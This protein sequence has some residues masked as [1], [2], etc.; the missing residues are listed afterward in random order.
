MTVVYPFLNDSEMKDIFNTSI[1]DLFVKM[2]Q[3]CHTKNLSM[4]PKYCFDVY[5]DKKPKY[6]ARLIDINGFPHSTNSI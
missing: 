2:K 3:A 1:N 5:I 6:K 4:S